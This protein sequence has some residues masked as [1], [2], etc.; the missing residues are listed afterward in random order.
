ME[1]SDGDVWKAQVTADRCEV[2]YKYVIVD[3]EGQVTQWKPGGNFEVKLEGFQGKVQIEDAWDGS[4]HEVKTSGTWEEPPPFAKE[5]ISAPPASVE[6]PPI[7]PTVE[8]QAPSLDIVCSA[9]SSEFDDVLKEALEHTYNELQDTLDESY[10]LLDQVSPDDPR[11]LMNDQKLA[12]VHQ[13]ATSLSKAIDAGAPPPSYILKEIDK[14]EGQ[15]DT[16][17]NDQS[18]Q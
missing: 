9:V 17:G 7:V 15:P 12:A 2:E 4:F 14:D 5:Q 13:K 6:P 18:S 11:L 1:W 3:Q 8:D 10:D 16:T